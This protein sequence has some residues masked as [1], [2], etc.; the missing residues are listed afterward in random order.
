MMEEKALYEL[1]SVHFIYFLIF[2]IS[3]GVKHK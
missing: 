2:N 1:H 3:L